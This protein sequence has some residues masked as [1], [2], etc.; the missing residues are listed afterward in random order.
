VLGAAAARSRLAALLKSENLYTRPASSH[1]GHVITCLTHSQFPKPQQ[2]KPNQTKSNQIK[3]N[4]TKPD[5]TNPDP[6]SPAN[7]GHPKAAF[8][9]TF[10]KFSFFSWSRHPAPEGQLAI[11]PVPSSPFR[12]RPPRNRRRPDP[13]S[14]KTQ[15]TQRPL[16]SSRIS[17]WSTKT[18]LN[19]TQTNQTTKNI[20]PMASARAA[21]PNINVDYFSLPKRQSEVRCPLALSS[22]SIIPE[23][24]YFL[25]LTYLG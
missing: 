2:T 20:P 11:H 21:R 19:P 5:K 18:R 1:R 10:H 25:F 22:A 7:R 15:L 13:N 6:T 23:Q 17:A 24:K 3:S 9:L 8:I 12:P 14:S 16:G 4:Q